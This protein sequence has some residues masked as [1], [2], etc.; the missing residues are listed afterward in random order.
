MTSPSTSLTK[1][2]LTLSPSA[3]KNATQNPFLEAAGRGTL[4]KEVLSQ[5]LSQ[6]RLYAQSYVRFASKVIS[7]ITLPTS[8]NPEDLNERYSFFLS[9]DATILRMDRIVDLLLD[10]LTNVRRELKFFEEVASRYDLNISATEESEGVQ[11]YKRLFE[12]TSQ[13]SLHLLEALVLLWGTEKVSPPF[14]VSWGGMLILGGCSVILKLG[15]MPKRLRMRGRER[16]MV[17]PSEKNS[18]L[19]GRVLSSSNS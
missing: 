8:V 9:A 15:D 17:G 4:S 7:Q 3:F 14:P 1:D 19:T 18:F 10:A 11:G 2:L 16:K 12:Q 5:W 13:K 6:D